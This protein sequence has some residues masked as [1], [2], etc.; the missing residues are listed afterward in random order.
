MR[1][2]LLS[3]IVCAALHRHCE[4]SDSVRW[5]PGDTM[6]NPVKFLD[7]GNDGIKVDQQGN[8]YSTVRG[9]EIWITS[10]GGRRLGTL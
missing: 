2:V 5:P 9:N 1:F 3:Q 6:A 8:V 4:E 7:A 10:P